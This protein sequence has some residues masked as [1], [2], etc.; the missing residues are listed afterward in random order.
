M[1]DQ[2][3]LSRAAARRHDPRVDEPTGADRR[4][5]RRWL[6]LLAFCPLCVGVV[7]WATFDLNGSYP[8]VKPPVPAGWQAVRG[9]YA[10]FSVPKAWSLQQQLSD[11][12]G[13]VYYAGQGGGA[14][15]SVDQADIAPALG[16]PPASIVGAFLQ[17]HYEVASVS[18]Y[19]LANATVAWLYRFRLSDGTAALG[20][21]AWARA[22]QTEVWL[23]ASPVSATTERAL[24]TLALAR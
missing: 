13:D 21:H 16:T 14:G 24:S 22:T 7:V 9:I 2:G 18:R 4:R 17:E 12:V 20:V 8:T 11:D 19:K 3:T 15:L 10:S 5:V 6:I 1:A 23:V